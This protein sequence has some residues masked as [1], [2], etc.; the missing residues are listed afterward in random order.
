MNV[1]VRLL[2]S[3]VTHKASSEMSARVLTRAQRAAAGPFQGADRL[4]AGLPQGQVVLVLRRDPRRAQRGPHVQTQREED[5]RE[6]HQ[7][8]GRQRRHP[9]L[10][11][12]AHR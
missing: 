9:D 1:G 6:S 4:P 11:R 3:G 7:L 8:E 10:L 12:A 2:L 5:A